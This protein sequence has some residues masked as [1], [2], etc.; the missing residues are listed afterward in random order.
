MSTTSRFEALAQQARENLF[1]KLAEDPFQSIINAVQD[2]RTQLESV[3]NLLQQSAEGA[4]RSAGTEIYEFV[5]LIVRTNVPR[6]PINQILARPDIQQMLRRPFDEA[7]EASIDAA[8]QAWQ[9]GLD[10]GIESVQQAASATGLEIPDQWDAP[11]DSYLQ[12]VI[13]DIERNTDAATTRF[14]DAIANS[15]E[16]GLQSALQKEANDL[17]Y[18]SRYS[19]NVV[20]TRAA[21]AQQEAAYKQLAEKNGV[22]IKKVWVTRFGPGTCRTCARLHGTVRDLGKPFPSTAIFGGGKPPSVYGGLSGPPRHPNC[23]CYIA[24]YIDQFD[25]GPVNSETMK[26]FAQTWWEKLLQW[27]GIPV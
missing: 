17:G 26:D 5:D 15:P 9:A 20:G 23:R 6:K 10:S 7:K 27:L 19:V 25:E 18:R 22:V 24:L 2:Q 3:T 11:S 12:Q 4:W 8:K 13:S 1:I 14:Y 21:A 16:E